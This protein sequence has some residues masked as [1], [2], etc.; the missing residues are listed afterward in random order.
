MLR[1]GLGGGK[2]IEDRD[3]AFNRAEELLREAHLEPVYLAVKG[4]VVYELPGTHGDIDVRAVHLSGTEEALAIRKP[5]HTFEKMEGELDLVAWEADRFFQHLLHHN[6]NMI[7]L[8]L[9]PERY[10][11]FGTRGQSLR[12]IGEKFLTQRLYDYY[13]GYGRTQFDDAQRTG[14]GKAAIYAYREMYAG[15]WL[16]LTGEIIFPWAELREKVEAGGVFRSSV[17]DDFDMDHERLTDEILQAM[18][19]E[20]ESMNQELAKAVE[21]SALPPDYDGYE[22]CNR[23]LLSWRSQRWGGPV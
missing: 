5:R 10:A 6:G 4:S 13:K 3:L 2:M 14:N 21:R 23:L 15:I 17:L 11:R 1:R 9:T 19:P 7:E 22:V 20:F 8:L 18:R 12:L 16:L